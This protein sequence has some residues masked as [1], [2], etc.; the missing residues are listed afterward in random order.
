MPDPIPPPAAR[1]PHEVLELV[2]L[3][4]S[5]GDLEAALAQYEPGAPLQPWIREAASDGDG[6]SEILLGLMELRRRGLTGATTDTLSINL[7]R[8]PVGTGIP[9]A[10]W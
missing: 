7:D 8:T 9:V 6:V 10:A 1:R 2:S 5:D 3:A 4:L